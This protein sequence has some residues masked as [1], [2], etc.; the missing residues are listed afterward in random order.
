MKTLVIDNL[1]ILLKLAGC[2][3]IMLAVLNLF[4]ERLLGWKSAIAAMPL[5]IREVFQIHGWFI[6]ITCAMF[7]VITFRFAPAMATY[8]HEMMR[9]FAGGVGTFWGIRCIMQ[10]THYS[11]VHWKGILRETLIHWFLF[12]VYGAWAGLYFLAAFGK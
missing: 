2:G 8:E 4:L 11:A 12:L 7:G 6:S 9:W 3:Q 10:W 5:L 1:V